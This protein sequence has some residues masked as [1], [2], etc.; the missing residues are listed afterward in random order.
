MSTSLPP[1]APLTPTRSNENQGSLADPPPTKPSATAAAPAAS[2]PPP[3]PAPSGS[4]SLLAFSPPPKPF[5]PPFPA[6]PPSPPVL[7]LAKFSPGSFLDYGASHPP[8]LPA[9]LPVLLSNPSPFPVSVSCA[10]ACTFQL[11]PQSITVP[12]S[13]TA[14]AQLVWTP[15]AGGRARELVR[16]R[17]AAGGRSLGA[18]QVTCVGEALGAPEPT[19]GRPGKGRPGKGRP[20]GRSGGGRPKLAVATGGAAGPPAAGAAKPRAST[21]PSLSLP[22]PRPRRSLAAAQPALSWEEK[23]AHAFASWLNYQF[24]P[25][26]AVMHE[27]ELSLLLESPSAAAAT[28]SQDRTAL[29]T[30]LLHRRSAATRKA[31]LAV[32]NSAPFAE[33]RARL[34]AEIAGGGLAVRRDRDTHADLGLRGQLSEALLSYHPD[35][36]RASLEAAFGEGAAAALAKPG[37]R[38]RKLKAFVATHVL[39][40]APTLAKYTAGQRVKV[41]SGKFEREYKEELGRVTLERVLVQVAFLDRARGGGETPCLFKKDS[42]VKST[43]A[44][45]INLCRDFLSGE[46]DFIKH[47]THMGFPPT[48]EQAFVDEYD[49]KVSDL[50]A[51]LRDGVRLCR[52]AEILTGTPNKSLSR[53]LR[54]PA[55][56]RLQKLH[57]TNLA[58]ACLSG[59]GVDTSNLSA[60]DVVDGNNKGVFALLWRCLVHFKLS[61][62]I[63]KD[64]LIQEIK[65]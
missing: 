43:K 62:L 25:P 32:Y 29:R 31:A 2:A 51:D 11:H 63:N 41:P 45:L 26:E 42:A 1:R 33:L 40:D 57:N 10:G 47:L 24:E 27:D 21:T 3:A 65:D 30:L 46:G 34:R 52:L 8:G 19:R 37:P 18:L 22:K 48:Y 7:T 9:P 50:S 20:A 38:A 15:A 16:L 58:L 55:V 23:Q 54:V 53:Q 64:V 56:S 28:A 60:K 44:L 13:S 35:W 5:P 61:Q 14:P 4:S 6:P 17:L 49:F 36:L 39:S 12:P 59:A